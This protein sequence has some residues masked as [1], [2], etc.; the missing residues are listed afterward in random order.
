[1]RSVGRFFWLSMW[2]AAGALLGFVVVPAALVI[3]R[4][5]GAVM[6][7]AA[8]KE[9][10]FALLNSF[11]CALAAAAIAALLGLPL[12][13]ILATRRIPL[14]RLVEALVDL[15]LAV[16]H[17]VA[18]IALLWTLGKPGLGGLLGWDFVGTY[19]A[20][21]A[22]MLFVS[23][24]YAVNGAREGFELVNPRLGQVARVLGA[25]EW[26]VFVGVYL[27]IARRAVLA[28]LLLT[29][30][31]AVSE[32][33]AVII[34]AYHPMTAP[35]LIWHRFETGGLAAS[36]PVAALLLACSLCVF[37]ILR[38]LLWRRPED[39]SA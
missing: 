17:S 22:A 26:R 9:V 4:P 21:I 29:W 24:P 11:L 37:V 5:G 18:G 27:P 19:P 25:S 36:G 38:I 28:G 30:A 13:Y 23:L 35:V 12:A 7:A 39:G 31:R 15:P 6:K 2:F 14:K 20:I 16:P 3:L 33:G 32:F 1:M 34:L 10:L 8:E